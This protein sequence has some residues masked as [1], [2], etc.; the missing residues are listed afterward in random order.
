MNA[1][2]NQ[3]ACPPQTAHVRMKFK[4]V[5]ITGAPGSGKGTQGKLLG[6]L[7]GFFHCACGDVFR[8]LD[9]ESESS[10]IFKERCTRGEFV[11]DE[12]TV[13]IWQHAIRSHINAGRFVPKN[14]KLILDGIPRNV[15][16]CELLNEFLDVKAVIHLQGL[17]EEC[18]IQ[19]I[20]QRSKKENRLDDGNAETVRQRLAIFQNETMCISKFYPAHLNYFVSADGSPQRVSN[21]ILAALS[22]LFD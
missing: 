9:P 2:H 6:Q 4:T 16:Q 15:R 19:R 7:P 17:S 21:E 22:G 8:S 12:L 10:R 1:D 14:S 20:L 5:L 13:S 11:P 18:L 3:F